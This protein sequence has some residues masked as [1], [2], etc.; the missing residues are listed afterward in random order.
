MWLF[1]SLVFLVL[2]FSAAIAGISAAP[3]L[4]TRGKERKQL[5]EEISLKHGDKVVDLGCGDGS[6]LF[7]IAKAFPGADYTGYEISLLPL[8]IAH[9]RRDVY[10]KVYKN[11]KIRF[12]NL[13]TKPIKDFNVVLVFLLPKSYPRLIKRFKTELKDNA[14][15]IVEAWPLPGIEPVKKVKKEGCLSL[16]F[17]T[18]K[19]FRGVE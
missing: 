8:F 1:A 4:P 9:A 13:Y 10:R 17:Y 11:V 16:Y 18:G 14:M 19:Q 3:W 15:V 7:A 2:I 12:G 6:L 5:I